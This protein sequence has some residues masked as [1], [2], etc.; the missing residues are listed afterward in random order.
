MD[1][2]VLLV[3]GIAFQAYAARIA[4]GVHLKRQQ[5]LAFSGDDWFQQLKAYEEG[6]EFERKGSVAVINIRGFLSFAYDFWTWWMDGSSYC[7]VM[8]KVRA[9]ADDSG[10]TK[11]ILNVNS[12][13]GGTIG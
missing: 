8:N 3:D 7:G 9:A 10:V 5:M 1:S 4:Q 13:G 11:I 2:S 12:P 6:T